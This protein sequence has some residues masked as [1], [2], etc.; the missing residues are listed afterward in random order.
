MKKLLFI[1]LLI[2]CQVKEPVQTA[3]PLSYSTPE[4][5]G[6]SSKAILNFIESA[7]Q[8]QPNALHS[9]ILVRH[10]KIIA[11]G[12]WSPYNPESPHQLYS[13][14]KSF[15]ST[16][17]GLA[18]DEDIISLDDP[19]ISFF[20][21]KIPENPSENLKSM[22]VRDLLKMNTGHE[23]DAS[24]RMRDPDKGWVAGFL[25]L[26]VERKP[27][28]IFVYNSG[29]TYM[30]S[31]IIQEVTGKKLVEYLQPKLFDP[32][33]IKPPLWQSDPDGINIGGWGLFLTTNDIA[34]FGQLYLQK[35]KWNGQQIVPES[36]VEQA[37]SYQ[38]SNGSNPESDWEQ[39]YCFQFWRCRHNAYRGDGAFGQ[40][41][42]VMPDQDAVLA[43]TSG[44]S[45][46]QGILKLV[47]NNILD[48]M[49]AEALPADESSLSALQDK[50][51][52]LAIAT[53]EGDESSAIAS[54]VSGKTYK[55]E[56]NEQNIEEILFNF[57]GKENV[58]TLTIG[59]SD[60]EMPVGYQTMLKG[61]MNLSGLGNLAVASSGAWTSENT[62]RATMINYES[63]HAITFTFN[64]KGDDL[65]I[66][67]EY[68]VMF[69]PA[70]RP[71][72]K[73][74]IE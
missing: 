63:P 17:I 39:G 38:S 32:L 48:G 9:F 6:I 28:T 15:T 72:M 21:D 25:S 26:P 11:E 7:E 50:L 13:L 49:N 64:F 5:E 44:S 54:E 20:P 42:I 69:G 61:T 4:A 70:K 12:W 30:L 68:N 47:W 31:A 37:T 41:C 10:G 60:Q 18:V 35:G 59:G 45:D 24:G 67:T 22:R 40:Y 33:D 52:K 43:I 36:W 66:D 71:Q 51:S 53:V 29:A 73:G 55:I 58:V 14:S 62:Y 34:K 56:P 46:M 27:G 65:L 19:V 2:S 23:V 16:A 8:E 3:E 1:L 57:E 74:K